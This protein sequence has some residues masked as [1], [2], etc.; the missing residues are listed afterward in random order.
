MSYSIFRIEG[1]SKT[2][3]LR[4]IG[5]HNAE[6]I[7]HTN[8]D[9][10]REKSSENIELV[11]CE[12][13]MQ[14]FNEITADMKTEHDERMKTMRKDRRKTFD[15]AVNSAKNDV[16]CEMLFT[17]DSE[18]FKGRSREEIEA[19]GRQSLEFVE[20][21]IG[22][23]KDK[24]IHASIHMDEKTPHLHVVAV[25][26][27]EIYDGRRKK[28]V[29]TISRHQFI[30]TTDDLSKLQDKY[31]EQMKSY[32]YDMQRGES[33]NARHEKIV[34]FKEKTNYHEEVAKQTKKHAMD[35][36]RVVESLETKQ[37]GLEF[38]ISSKEYRLKQLDKNLKTTKQL[39]E[40]QVKTK[41]GLIRSKTVELS[42]EDFEGIKTLAQATEGVRKQNKSLEG[43]NTKLADKIDTVT[44]QNAMLLRENER[45]R[46]ERDEYKS[47]YKVLEKLI[48][49]LQ[50]VYKEK[51]PQSLKAFEQALGY[52][53]HQVNRT[54]SVFKGDREEDKFSKVSMSKNEQ[55]GYEL[56]QKE[57]KIKSR[58]MERS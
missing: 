26:L 36:K 22:L 6:R 35:V 7:S 17:S 11:E 44:Q 39:D 24:I 15:E 52:A 48:T 3:D 8:L 12:S 55:L 51:L 14:R 29:L 49:K 46:K 50:E 31:N 27:T 30:K 21:E 37:T 13:Y 56:A 16:A 47:K 53:K 5:K 25:P 1:I 38:I 34:K 58:G 2:S 57:E 9:I 28:D 23:T 54:I 45:L 10:D 19:W 18:F 40:I 4:G 42:L 20:K 32:G 43:E 41:G 33:K